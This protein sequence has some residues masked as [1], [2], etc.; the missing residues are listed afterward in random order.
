MTYIFPI[1]SNCQTQHYLNKMKK[2]LLILALSAMLPMLLSCTSEKQILTNLTGT[3]V[4]SEI[5]DRDVPDN[6]KIVLY[7]DGKGNQTFA[8]GYQMSADST[9]WKET[10]YSYQIKNNIITLEG[11]DARSDHWVIQIRIKSMDDEE[12][13]YKISFQT[14]NGERVSDNKHYSF[15]KVDDFYH[16]SL[17]GMWK[18]IRVTTGKPFGGF[19]GIEYLANGKYNYYTLNENEEWVLADDTG[20]YF[21]YGD[22]LATMWGTTYE[23]WDIEIEGSTMNWEARRENNQIEYFTFTKETK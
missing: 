22:L 6:D 10:T 2:T 13:D 21:L 9:I 5:N 4:L 14:K 8:C 23:N 17:L 15:S 1:K 19:V 12:M 11:D 3:W 16:T 7:F 18:G 20:V